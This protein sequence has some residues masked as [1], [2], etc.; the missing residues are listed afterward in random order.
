[1]VIGE[2]PPSLREGLSSL[3]VDVLPLRSSSGLAECWRPGVLVIWMCDHA[4]DD[5]IAALASDVPETIR[6]HSV[7]CGELPPEDVGRRIREVGAL[8]WIR[9]PPPGW[10]LTTILDAIARSDTSHL[11]HLA[12]LRA[13]QSTID[14]DPRRVLLRLATVAGELFGSEL[15]VVTMEGG[16]PREVRVLHEDTDGGVV[17][18]RWRDRPGE[19]SP[20]MGLLSHAVRFG[21]VIVIPA[22]SASKMCAPLP[23]E[24]RYEA[25]VAVP[26]RTPLDDMLYGQLYGRGELVAVINL[27]WRLP[28]M[29]TVAEY[30]LLE[31]LGTLGSAVL[32]RLAERIRGSA[33]RRE[34]T[35]ALARLL[36]PDYGWDA[37]ALEG[38]V[39]PLVRGRLFAYAST[40]PALALWARV[41]TGSRQETSWVTWG[42]PD[43]PGEPELPPQVFTSPGW[44]SDAE[45]LDYGTDGAVAL[46]TTVGA[47]S[48]P[49]GHVVAVY[50][51]RADARIAREEVRSLA[52]ELDLALRIARG[53]AVHQALVRIAAELASQT[54]P[55][56][57]LGAVMQVV[58][59]LMSS[60]GA[61]VYVVVQVGGE[62]RLRQLYRTDVRPTRLTTLSGER[63]LGDWVIR[64]NDWLMVGVE[65]EPAGV[66]S[67]RPP[68][69]GGGLPVVCLSGANGVAQ[70]LARPRADYGLEGPDDER[71]MLL[72]PLSTHGEVAGALAVWRTTQSPYDPDADVTSLQQLAPHIAAACERV[73]HLEKTEEEFRATS[74]LGV[75]LRPDESVRAVERAVARRAGE[76]ANA[77]GALLLWHHDGQPGRL[78]RGA[79]WVAGERRSEGQGVGPH[80]SA[81][82]GPRG[83]ADGGTDGRDAAG[84]GG[85]GS[86]GGAGALSE[87]LME[88]LRGCCED[89]G[90]DPRRW[91]DQLSS[92]FAGRLPPGTLRVRT[93][94]P[95]PTRQD[96]R[97]QGLVVLFDNAAPPTPAFG[98]AVADQAARTWLEHAG[99][100]L[101]NHL[102]AHAAGLAEQLA[103]AGNG[104]PASRNLGDLNDG[105]GRG[106]GPEEVLKTAVELL[107]RA[108]GADLV[109]AWRGDPT[110]LHLVAVSEPP[111][112]VA[113]PPPREL[114]QTSC[115]NVA[116]V[117][118]VEVQ[119]ANNVLGLGPLLAII[120]RWRGWERIRS[121]VWSPLL[122]DGE[123]HPL[124]ALLALTRERGC[125]L[126]VRQAAV[127]RAFADRTAGELQKATRRTMLED[128]RAM[129]A[130]LAP[131][132]GAELGRLI[133]QEVEPWAD[134]Y[135][136]SGV[137]V[138]VYARGAN[139]QELVS[140]WSEGLRVDLVDRLRL[141]SGSHIAK[142]RRWSSYTPVRQGESLLPVGLAG[143]AAP[144]SIPGHA[145]LRG[146]L[147]VLDG[148]DFSSEQEHVLQEAAH[149]VA[150]PL[151]ADRRRMDYTLQGGLFRHA[152]LGPVQ[153][154]T[155]AAQ[156]LAKLAIRGELTPE[157]AHKLAADVRMEAETIRTWRE[158]QRTHGGIGSDG[159]MEI[160]AKVQPLRS[161]VQRCVQRFEGVA[162]T[163]GL[164]LTELW[165]GGSLDFAFDADALDLALSNLLHNAIKY[166]YF[167][168]EITV[169]VSKKADM[170]NLYVEDVGHPIPAK[171]Q[172]ELYKLGTRAVGRDPIRAIAGEGLGLFMVRAVVAAHGGR[173]T[174]SCRV[175]AARDSGDRTPYRVR[176]TV[177]L[178]HNWKRR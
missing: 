25:A 164:K 86:P 99:T 59:E 101:E 94:L 75:L 119:R 157:L 149:E 40:P 124:G 121:A 97:P 18:R 83:P 140:A 102:R 178:P 52:A 20:T 165:E 38:A 123:G 71:T 74:L 106:R 65:R 70:V 98:L 173:V 84:P 29:P 144:I 45:P 105:R 64:Q 166:A 32:T 131:A 110:R 17:L 137:K 1:M 141:V 92:L 26:I 13:L 33:S 58:R 169:G 36:R 82:S 139:D 50:E 100:V 125:F 37:K 174:H 88:L 111:G 93:I 116:P 175:E 177:E 39:N 21:A 135:V 150:L 72:V 172:E 115:P 48:M 34:G 66:P 118:L 14:D 42:V 68:A 126:G 130:R 56:G 109:L 142:S 7:L 44:A 55:T 63:G 76:L 35:L 2:V 127:T 170:V 30:R 176:F 53:A 8:S 138:A 12:Q 95:L 122:L 78:H 90:G 79:L 112:S 128:L 148:A 23:P 67:V 89:L 171:I 143:I 80:L 91:S 28:R 11:E 61:K 9:L 160:R 47:A 24:P 113:G 87:E 22:V 6:A 103:A 129:A 51:R 147:F 15:S 27:F 5:A 85:G 161:V 104:A 162:T 108:S 69:V 151:E 132:A 41:S 4:W 57:A 145:E 43:P 120:R 168:R 81:L 114:L 60:D 62:A 46:V 167:N 136:R 49:A 158:T 163:R 117:S 96:G 153:G 107:F 156:H 54:S 73:L 146:H 134:R 152:L 77:A 19:P 31:V 133:V 159:H 3:G 10:V 154:V 16:T 155:D